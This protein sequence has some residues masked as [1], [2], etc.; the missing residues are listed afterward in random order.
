LMHGTTLM[1]SSQL[2]PLLPFLGTVFCMV[3]KLVVVMLL[4]RLSSM[5]PSATEEVG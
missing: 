4:A 3:V 5:R 2:L 1:L